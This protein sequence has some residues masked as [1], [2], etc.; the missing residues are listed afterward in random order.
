MF[1]YSKSAYMPLGILSS[2]SLEV[3]LVFEP[4]VVSEKEKKIK[5]SYL[6]LSALFTFPR[7]ADPSLHVT[8]F[9]SECTKSVKFIAYFTR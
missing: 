4:P 8:H 7:R 2:T 9:S 1:G 5:Q 6:P 3:A